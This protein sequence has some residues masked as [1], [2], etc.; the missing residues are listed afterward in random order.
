MSRISKVFHISYLQILSE[1][2]V[3]NDKLMPKLS[4]NDIHKLYELMILSRRFDETALKLQREGRISTYASVYGE[5]A[6]QVGS[7]FVL[8]DEDWIFPTFRDMAAFITRGFPMHMLYQ[9]WGGD[10]RGMKIPDNLNIF[11]VAVP[12]A[13]QIPHAV[14]A[15][16]GMKL[17]GKKTASLV[18]LGDGA[19]SKGDFHE[20]M[21]FAGVFKLP[22]IFVCENNQW[23][24]SLPRTKQTAS[25]TIAQK[26]V[27]YGME[28][29]QI[30]GNDI[31]AV[32]KATQEALQKARA[33]LGPTF[34]ECVTYRLS[35]HT[36]ADDASRYRNA[37]DVEKWKKKEPVERLR[38]WMERKG[39]WNGNY[40]A[41]VIKDANEKVEKAVKDYESVTPASPEDIVKYTYAE[42]PWNLK[43]QLAQLVADIVAKQQEPKEEVKTEKKVE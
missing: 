14:G 42:I 19:T 39:Y 21:N 6:T 5:E 8:Q 10:E 9:Y 11:P 28:G 31:F 3:C 40:E 41:R 23:A 12:V 18:Y 32:I 7:A 22:C 17:K 29:I 13:S 34:I 16:W 35:D 4:D 36:T 30:D 38:K 2:G 27:A 1:S 20:A 25:E 26:A 24:I 33:G 15:A 37:K 43:E